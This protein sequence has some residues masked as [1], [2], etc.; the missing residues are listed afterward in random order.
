M[1]NRSRTD[2]TAQILE[3]V[4]EKGSLTKTQIMYVAY[5]SYSQLIDYLA[6]LEHHELL[7]VD[8]GGKYSI[9]KKGQSFRAALKEVQKVLSV[10]KPIVLA[11]KA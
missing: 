10:K 9:T 4:E 1:K 7:R 2:I 3:M 6:L 11:A 8:D 5:V